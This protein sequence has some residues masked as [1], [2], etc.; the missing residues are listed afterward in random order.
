M[1]GV[2]SSCAKPGSVPL[3]HSCMCRSDLATRRRGDPLPHEAVN[4]ESKVDMRN[5]GPA[6]CSPT[7]SGSQTGTTTS[8]SYTVLTV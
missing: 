4:H 8:P 6:Y 1:Q 7:T 3:D 2:S 5:T